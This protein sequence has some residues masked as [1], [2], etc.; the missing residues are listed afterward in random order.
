MSEWI[1]YT[2]NTSP[3]TD[4]TY[5]QIETASGAVA[6]N[7]ARKFNWHVRS[8]SY[9]IARFRVLSIPPLAPP[10]S[11]VPPKPKQPTHSELQ[12]LDQLKLKIDLWDE[13]RHKNA[14]RLLQKVYS[15]SSPWVDIN[16]FVKVLAAHADTVRDALQPY[17]S[18]VRDEGPDGE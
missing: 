9:R 8:E 12:Q 6:K 14:C 4:D 11:D 13:W 16:H 10:A 17:D 15:E 7:Y 2:E 5:V 3:P 1:E 18:G